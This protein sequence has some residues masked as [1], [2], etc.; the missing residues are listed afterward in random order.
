VDAIA[1]DSRSVQN[2]DGTGLT[3]SNDSMNESGRV[4]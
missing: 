1:V 2:P 4:L 3:L